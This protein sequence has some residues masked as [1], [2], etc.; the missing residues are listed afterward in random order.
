MSVDVANL[1]IQ[2]DSKGVRRSENDLDNLERQGKKTQDRFTSFGQTAQRL[3][4]QLTRWLTLP[5]VGAGAAAIKTASDYETLRTQ[6]EV[7]V[8]SAET[9]NTVFNDLVEFAATTPFE[10]DGITRANN[11]LLGFGVSIDQTQELLRT[12]GDVAAVSGGD[13]FSVARVFGEARAEGRLLTRDLRQ[14]I[15][16]GVPAPKLLAESMG[17]AEG[18]I[19]DLASQGEITFERLVRS[20]EMATSQGGLF[21]EGMSKRSNTLAGIFSNFADSASQSLSRVGNTL[22]ETL[23]IKD[24]VRDLI[25]QIDLATD[26]FTELDESSQRMIISFGLL[27]AAAGP[28]IG[29]LGTLSLAIGAISAPVAAVVA[30]IAV[31]T[32]AIIT[33]WEDV[34]AYFTSGG[35]AEM[36][37]S[38]KNIVRDTVNIVTRFWEQFGDHIMTIT[39]ESFGIV[40]DI[41]SASLDAIE[42][43]VG[44]FSSAYDGKYKQA[45]MKAEAGWRTHMEN[46]GGIVERGLL[47][48]RNFDV[49]GGYKIWEALGLIPSAEELRQ[50]YA[51]RMQQALED[52]RGDVQMPEPVIMDADID[53]VNLEANLTHRFS[54]LSDKFSIP[55]E[56]A[57]DTIIDPAEEAR[58]S[59]IRREFDEMQRTLEE[60]TGTASGL[61]FL[62]RLPSPN[63]IAGVEQAIANLENQFRLA[64][65]AQKRAFIAEDIEEY[66][67]QL[68][69]MRGDVEGVSQT[70]KDLGFTFSSAFEDA[71]VS[72]NSFRDVLDGILQDLLRIST[73]SLITKPLGNALSGALD[74]IS[75]GG[76]GSVEPVNDLIITDSG[77]VF[78]PSPQDTIMAMKHPERMNGGG[79]KVSVNVSVV[80]QSSNADVDVQQRRDSNGNV[81]LITIVKDISKGLHDSGQMDRTMR[82]NYGVTRKASRRG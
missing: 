25:A 60:L 35:G 14:L 45:F 76:G 16:Q 44:T 80:N 49:V 50:Q 24:L 40:I 68:E 20:F 41:V 64:E 38:L 5:I 43:I 15:A 57:A 28:V 30:A 27:L 36:W 72:G 6:L 81:E 54:D 26:W 7:L 22:I 73:R 55:V 1:Q 67:E 32:A 31:G 34:E 71:I 78:K 75:F 19:F 37:E 4:G 39:T 42:T 46:V 74:G 52:A 77:R 65:D 58:I 70:A 9:A 8:G 51:Q 2:I 18:A 11:L 82:N 12:L 48:L 3:S 29:I 79:S 10:I 53:L 69:L 63:S 33:H 66:R 47:A 23:G 21:F 13:L 61:D 17:V 56:L 62:E 59:S